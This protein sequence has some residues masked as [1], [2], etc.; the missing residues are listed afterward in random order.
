MKSGYDQ[1]FQKAKQ[2]SHKQP[3][4]NPSISFTQKKQIVKKRKKTF[5]KVILSS[6][7]GF[8]VT[9]SAYIYLD[10]VS[11]FAQKIE[12]NFLGEVEAKEADLKSASDKSSI[13]KSSAKRPEGKPSE[14]T[15]ETVAK[16][17]KKSGNSQLDS[18]DDNHLA[19]LQER[20]EQLDAREKELKRF[21]EELQ[22]QKEEVEKKLTDLQ[23]TRDT[24]SKSLENKVQMDEKKVD[25]LVQV[26]STMKPQSAAKIFETMDED[27]V[28]EILSRMK[29]KN[30]AEILNTIKADKAKVLGEKSAGIK[31]EIASE[32]VKE[33]EKGTEKTTDST[34]GE[35]KGP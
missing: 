10:D 26:Y 5:S 9:L 30:A 6:A 25:A 19:K 1:F 35:K 16:D 22:K 31:R 34:K 4:R 20:D 2:N 15:E 23:Q 3:K 32:P 18:E 17:E 28:V 11:R 33:K 12:V 13:E 21:E 14:G 24:I 8:I 27:L 7:F 29:K